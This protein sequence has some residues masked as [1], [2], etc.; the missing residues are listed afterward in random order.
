M[1]RSWN[2]EKSYRTCPSEEQFKD[3]LEKYF[4]DKGIIPP[5]SYSRSVDQL[6]LLLKYGAEVR[7]LISNVDYYIGSIA[8]ARGH[9]YFYESY[10]GLAKELLKRSDIHLDNFKIFDSLFRAYDYSYLVDGDR[11]R[12]LD[13]IRAVIQHSNVNLNVRGGAHDLTPK[14]SACKWAQ[15]DE[16]YSPPHKFNEVCALFP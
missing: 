1:D 10:Y 7:E 3:V 5:A 11:L 6:Q 15:D 9:K 8:R 2:D 12:I 16:K 14:E 13:L 4:L